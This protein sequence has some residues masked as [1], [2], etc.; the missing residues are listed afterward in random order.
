MKSASLRYQ[1]LTMFACSGIGNNLVASPHYSFSPEKPQQSVNQGMS[2]K[3]KRRHRLV[4][5]EFKPFNRYASFDSP[6]LSSSP[7]TAGEERDGGWNGLNGWNILNLF[8]FVPSLRRARPLI[9][10]CNE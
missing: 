8:A 1:G 7:M 5:Q 4:P 2:L 10:A 3:E 6:F 9:V